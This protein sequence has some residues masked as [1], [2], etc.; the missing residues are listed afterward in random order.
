MTKPCPVCRTDTEN[1]DAPYL[2]HE[3]LRRLSQNMMAITSDGITYTLSTRDGSPITSW[4]VLAEEDV[5]W[6]GAWSDMVRNKSDELI[7][8]I[9]AIADTDIIKSLWDAVSEMQER[10]CPKIRVAIVHALFYRAKGTWRERILQVALHLEATRTTVV[11]AVAVAKAF[12]PKLEL[13]EQRY[14]DVSYSH[15]VVAASQPEPMKAIEKLAEL[16]DNGVYPSARA[17]REVLGGNVTDCQYIRT[18]QYC[19]VSGKVLDD[20]YTQCK[21]CTFHT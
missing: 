3:C 6:V 12:G 15:A 5:E 16:K 2:C 19:T 7:S 18:Q 20:G 14:P 9:S 11:E 21:D 13:L 4:P 17:F 10:S 8:R 1:P